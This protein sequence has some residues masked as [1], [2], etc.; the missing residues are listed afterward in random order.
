MNDSDATPS[1][2]YPPRITDAMISELVSEGHPGCRMGQEYCNDPAHQ[3]ASEI[4]QLAWEQRLD[5]RSSIQ[6]AADGR[7]ST[8]RIG[9]AWVQSFPSDPT[10]GGKEIESQLLW[11]GWDEVQE[12]LHQS[13]ER[14]LSGLTDDE[15]ELMLLRFQHRVPLR[16]IGDRV[17][18][19][20]DTV[21]RTLV[22]IIDK[23][24]GN[25]QV[26]LELMGKQARTYEEARAALLECALEGD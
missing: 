18:Y 21:S 11:P 13:M 5:D 26:E 14:F 7:T 10:A 3:R 17:G 12:A 6:H 4:R 8:M 9:T 23:L 24:R 15:K 19:S 1:L 2:R 25:I 16:E 20:K 22:E